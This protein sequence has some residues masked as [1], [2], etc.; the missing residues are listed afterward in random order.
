MKA[1][2]E[3]R[4]TL[5]KGEVCLGA[6]IGFAD[7]YISYALADYF[8]FL[9]LELEHCAMSADAVNGHFLAGYSKNVPV[10]VRLPGSGTYIIKPVLDSGA[11]GIIIPQVRNAEEVK[12]VVDDC[13]YYPVGRR[14]FGPRIPSNFDRNNGKEY[15]DWANRNVFVAV[16][17]ENMDAVDCIDEILRVPGL[18]SI[19]IGP[20]DLSASMGLLGEIN[21]PKVAETID[22]VIGKARDAGVFVGAGVGPD[23]DAAI[24]MIQRGVQWIQVGNDHHYIIKYAEGMTSEIKRRL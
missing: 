23:A 12:Q 11:S 1:V 16:M 24:K 5:Q 6:S 14:G 2:E 9:W 15:V 18:D 8:D 7:P 19:V 10:F 21:H 3:F 17:I 4:S 20:M 22:R 13:R